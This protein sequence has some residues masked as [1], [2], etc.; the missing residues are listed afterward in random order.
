ML[1]IQTGFEVVISLAGNANM[2]DQLQAGDGEGD[3]AMCV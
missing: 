2:K 1:N 3:F